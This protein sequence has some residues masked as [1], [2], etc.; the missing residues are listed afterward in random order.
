MSSEKEAFRNPFVVKLWWS[1]HDEYNLYLA[2]DFHPGGHLATQLSKWGRLGRDR[3]RFYTAEIVEG[4]EGLHAAGV[5]Y[6]DL[7]PENVLLAQDGHIVLVDFGLAADFFPNQRNPGCLLPHWMTANMANPTDT[8]RPQLHRHITD[9]LLG[10]ERDCCQSFVGTAEYLV[11]LLVRSRSS[12]ATVRDA[13]GSWTG[14]PQRS[15]EVC[16]ILTRSTGK[17]I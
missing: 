5:I 10:S 16:H 2:L 11:S 13:D 7:K 1:F 14:R 3:A 12:H 8:N 17:R 6:R 9:G 4:V 15:F